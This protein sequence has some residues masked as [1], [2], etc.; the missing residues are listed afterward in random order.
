MCCTTTLDESH[1]PRGREVIDK[2]EVAR[3]VRNVDVIDDVTGLG[4][5]QRQVTQR[6]DEVAPITDPLG[7][8]G[9]LPVGGLSSAAVS[10]EV[11][12]VSVDAIQARMGQRRVTEIKSG[13]PP[14]VSRDVVMSRF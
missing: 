2:Y 9:G 8:R 4:G 7:V 13:R 5:D 1:L 6:V 11:Q 14:R 3:G 10:G 12:G